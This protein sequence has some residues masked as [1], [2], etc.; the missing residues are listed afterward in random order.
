MLMIGAAMEGVAMRR[1]V[2]GG[3]L[4]GAVLPVVDQRIGRLVALLEDWAHWCRAMRVDLGYPNRA[5]G[6]VGG[7]AVLS[8][9]HVYDSVD[10]GIMQVV[11]A[12]V[13]DLPPTQGA[14]V[15][16]RYE[17]AAVFRFRDRYPYAQAIDEAHAALLVS[18]PRRGVV[19]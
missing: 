6:L 14:A 9:D 1:V 16:R 18:L 3:G 5:A 10:A 2:R 4:S 8:S 12:A 7:C 19:L 13:S 15:M 17:L 11:D